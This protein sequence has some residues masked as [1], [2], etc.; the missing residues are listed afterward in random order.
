[1]AEVGYRVIFVTGRREQHRLQTAIWLRTH[2]VPSFA[3]HMRGQYDE[4]SDAELKNAMRLTI[5]VEHEI[6]A[7][8]DD[9]DSVVAMWRQSGLTCLQVA[10]GDF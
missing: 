3:L 8:F 9:R 7:V 4:R 10:P 1:M 6:V 2:A 5:E